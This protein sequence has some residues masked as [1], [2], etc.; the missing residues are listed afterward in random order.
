[1]CFDVNPDRIFLVSQIYQVVNLL[2]S[3]EEDPLIRYY[4]PVHHSP[5]GPLAKAPSP[6]QMAPANPSGGSERWKSALAMRSS[7][8]G[9]GGSGNSREPV[10]DCVS[11]KLA[12][13]IAAELDAHK[14]DNPEFPV[15]PHVVIL[16]HHNF[17]HLCSLYQR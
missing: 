11:K 10:G 16:A 17:Q 1:M 4:R 2:A 13:A 9:L 8:G 3:L 5:L 12:T 14:L 6:G 7:A 15:R